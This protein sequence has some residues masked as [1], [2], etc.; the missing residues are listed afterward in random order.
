MN[1]RTDWRTD[2]FLEL[3][4]ELKCIFIWVWQAL[5]RCWCS[6]R[7]DVV[8]TPRA[9]GGLTRGHRPRPPRRTWWPP[10]SSS[11]SPCRGQPAWTASS[12]RWARWSVRNMQEIDN[13]L[14]KIS[15]ILPSS[16]FATRTNVLTV[17]AS[18][19]GPTRWDSIKKIKTPCPARWGRRRLSGGWRR[20]N[21]TD[22]Q[23]REE[24]K[25]TP[26]V[27]KQIT[28]LYETLVN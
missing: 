21:L 18:H 24:T 7:W 4:L 14:H 8:C 11:L 10:P 13:S 12:L 3:L 28:L 20:L 27:I 6:R 1:G 9:S 5:S 25:N 26:K 23:P 17:V 15:K 2:D 19:L 16:R 22:L